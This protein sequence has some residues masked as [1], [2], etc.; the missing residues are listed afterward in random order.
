LF[1]LIVECE[2]GWSR[3]H[4]KCVKLFEEL[5]TWSEK[6]H[7]CELNNATLISIHSSEEDHFV[8]NL[9]KHKDSVFIGGKR[10]SDS[11]RFEWI[12][13]KVFNYTNWANTQPTG[14]DYIL[15]D[16]NNGEWY[17]T[18]AESFPFLCQYILS[19]F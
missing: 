19:N 1:K 16:S 10:N 11:N 12:N 18:N 7:V 6:K 5:K 9:V 14:E 8:R 13:G 15:M 2:R 17:D 3:Y 4:N